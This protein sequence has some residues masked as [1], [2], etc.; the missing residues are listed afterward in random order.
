MGIW[1]VTSF[2][3]FAIFSGIPGNE[4][5]FIN[6][7][8]GYEYVYR[9]EGHSTIKDLGKFIVKAKVSTIYKLLWILHVSLLRFSW[10]PLLIQVLEIE[11]RHQTN[12]LI[13]VSTHIFRT[14]CKNQH[15]DT[16]ILFVIYLVF[17]IVKYSYLRS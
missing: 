13:K 11:V 6:F 8:N 9:Y 1:S 14:Y 5:K 16:T 3:L 10:N 12:N 2:F 4:G 17:I 15:I 7:K